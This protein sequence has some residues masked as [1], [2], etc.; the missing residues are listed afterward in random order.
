MSKKESKH[1]TSCTI[2][3]E[4]TEDILSVVTK[5]FQ[6]EIHVRFYNSGNLISG[7]LRYALNTDALGT[8]VALASRHTAKKLRRCSPE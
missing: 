4:N 8:F 7:S 5:V 6:T 3:W 1:I 2:S